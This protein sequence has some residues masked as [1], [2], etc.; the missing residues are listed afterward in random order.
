MQMVRYKII[1]IT[2]MNKLLLAGYIL[3]YMFRISHIPHLISLCIQMMIVVCLHFPLRN[4]IVLCAAEDE[5]HTPK[6]KNENQIVNNERAK[7]FFTSL[8][9]HCVI[10][11]SRFQGNKLILVIA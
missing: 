11:M 10:R 7:A 6:R 4:T 8:L 2:N 3:M 9:T 1:L 5:K